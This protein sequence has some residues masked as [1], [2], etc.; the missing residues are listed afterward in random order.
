MLIEYDFICKFHQ[1]YHRLLNIIRT[2][3]IYK[4]AI[5]TSSLLNYMSLNPKYKK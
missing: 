1:K 2:P 5:N 3:A 4:G